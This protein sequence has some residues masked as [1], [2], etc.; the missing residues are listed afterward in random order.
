M[1]KNKLLH[2][3]ILEEQLE[4]LQEAADQ[5]SIITGHSLDEVEEGI[6]RILTPDHEHIFVN[7]LYC[8]VCGDPAF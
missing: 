8:S 7:S 4:K 2:I 6:V 5:I 3:A 1:L